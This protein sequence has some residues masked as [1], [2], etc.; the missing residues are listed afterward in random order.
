MIINENILIW[1]GIIMGTYLMY[2][3]LFNRSKIAAADDSK[4][5][6]N[7]VLTAKEYKVKGQYDK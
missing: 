7:K 2:K 5:L 6:Y 4:Q 3:I 1:L